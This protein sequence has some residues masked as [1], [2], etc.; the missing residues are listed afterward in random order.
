MRYSLTQ[1]EDGT[2]DFLS[3]TLIVKGRALLLKCFVLSVLLSSDLPL[4]GRRESSLERLAVGE[5]R[6]CRSFPL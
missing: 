6:Y 5:F 1:R 3:S 4:Y 2:G